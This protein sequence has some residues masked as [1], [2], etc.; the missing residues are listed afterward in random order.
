MRDVLKVRKLTGTSSKG[1]ESSMSWKISMQ[2]LAIFNWFDL[3][4]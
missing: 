2:Y 4:Q 3:E 1:F